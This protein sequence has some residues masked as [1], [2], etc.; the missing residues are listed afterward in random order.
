MLAL[1]LLCAVGVGPACSTV[2][3][4]TIWERVG[5]AHDIDPLLL[6]AV[7]LQESRAMFADGAARPWPWTLRSPLIGGQHYASREVAAAQ[8]AMLA[9]NG[10]RVNVDIGLMQVNWYWNGHRVDAPT[11]LLDPVRNVEV[12][13]RILREAIDEQGG[14]LRE[15]IARYHSRKRS[16]GLAYADSVLTILSRLRNTAAATLLVSGKEAP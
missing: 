12:A 10:R 1:I 9:P 8:L 13:A 6:Y 15:G 7:A 4:E 5:R 16:R 14:D 11:D 2:D 3:A